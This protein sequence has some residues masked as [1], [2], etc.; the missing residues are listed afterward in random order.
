MLWYWKLD[1]IVDLLESIDYKLGQQNQK[2]QTASGTSPAAIY[3]PSPKAK[4]NPKTAA[5]NFEPLKD[6]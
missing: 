1:K 2:Q 6:E 5:K 4:V 3:T